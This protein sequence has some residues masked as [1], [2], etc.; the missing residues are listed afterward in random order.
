MKLRTIIFKCLAVLGATA[1]S[2]LAVELALRV[3]GA[4]TTHLD[5]KDA[6][7]EDGLGLGPGGFLKEGFVGQV[8]DGYGHTVPWINNAQGFRSEREFPVP[9]APNTYRILSLGDSFTGGYRVGQHQTFSFLLEQSLSEAHPDRNI[10]V[11][12]S[13]IEEPLTGVYYLASRGIDYAPN[14]VLFG[15]TLGNDLAQVHANMGQTYDV[16]DDFPF[17]VKLDDR[18]SRPD[19][20]R[21]IESQTLPAGC[22]TPRSA[23][24]KTA[25]PAWQDVYPWW[26]RRELRLVT[27][28]SRVGGRRRYDAPQTVVSNW[29]EYNAPR[30]FDSNGLGMFLK[31]PPESVR[32]AYDQ[33][34]KTLSALN[35]FCQAKHLDLLVVI[36]PQRFQVQDPD[37]ER[38]VEVYGLR[39]EYFDRELP[40]RQIADFCARHDIECL[41]PTE[42]MRAARTRV[43]KN[44]YLPNHDM[45]WNARGQSALAAALLPAVE[46]IVSRRP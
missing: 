21:Q 38:T 37:W 4:T 12:V 9:A 19:W 30:L 32:A 16:T 45:H 35:R 10:E 2:L 17:V 24:R 26:P 29:E 6:Y 1:L 31:Y 28:L 43:G 25:R 41:D 15:I 34:F 27:L 5:Y 39:P 18:D 7:R 8:E 46:R 13:V 33:L 11:M 42:S 22:V 14:L 40:N 36:F 44:F 3:V 20:V 23:S